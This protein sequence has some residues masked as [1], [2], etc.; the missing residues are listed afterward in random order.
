MSHG[1]PLLTQKELGSIAY[2]P[3]FPLER[4]VALK[5]KILFLGALVWLTDLL[6]K[7]QIIKLTYGIVRTLK[8]A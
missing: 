5:I 8:L 4:S 7:E 6:L 2:A 3:H 1:V